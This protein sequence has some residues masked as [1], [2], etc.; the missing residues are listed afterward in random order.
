MQ[1][2]KWIAPVLLLALAACQP[3]GQPAQETTVS[4]DTAAPFT[5]LTI[6]QFSEMMSGRDVVLLDV[7]TPEETAQGKIDGA[8]EINIMDDDF[9]EK[10]NALDKSKTYLIYCQ[11]GGRSA[12]A[13][14][15]MAEQGFAK[16]YNLP[17]GYGAWPAEKK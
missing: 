12:R 17:D 8:M 7:R 10:I 13:A 6:P 5:D 3:K 16:L 4:E 9:L 15:M 11:S 1:T 14:T 2:M